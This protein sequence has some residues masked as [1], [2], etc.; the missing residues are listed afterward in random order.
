VLEYTPRGAFGRMPWVTDMGASV[1]WTL[2]SDSVDLQARLSVYNLFNNQA[3]INVHSR[4][5]GAP[6]V[7]LPHFGE[8]TVWQSPRYMQL[9]VT[10]N[11]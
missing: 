6:G 7:K 5:E 10:Y 9:V 3:V 11:F 8:G 1:T 2:P 4:Y